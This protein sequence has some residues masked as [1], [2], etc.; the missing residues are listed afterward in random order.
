MRDGNR[1]PSAEDVARAA[2][3]GLRTVFRLFDDMEGLYRGCADIVRAEVMPFVERPFKAR[4]LDERIEELAD[5]RAEVFERIM[6]FRSFSDVHRHKSAYLQAGYDTLLRQQREIL[7]HAIGNAA[8]PG[9]PAFEALDLLMS[10][11]SWRRLRQDQRL[12]RR[13]ARE[14][15]VKAARAI[16]GFAP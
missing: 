2:G 15:Q 10:F 8:K 3:V 13:K 6:P 12:S 9:T 14:T 16:L 1:E 4:S 11:E 5:R 7:A